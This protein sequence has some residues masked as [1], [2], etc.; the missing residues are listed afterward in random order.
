[1]P[2]NQDAQSEPV[3]FV[4]IWSRGRHETSLGTVVGA[5]AVKNKAIPAPREMHGLS[6]IIKREMRS[7]CLV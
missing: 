7:L 4:R 3:H 6:K 5:G 1:M 2:F